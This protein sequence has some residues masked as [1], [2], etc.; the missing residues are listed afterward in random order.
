MGPS[1]RFTHV[2]Y[3]I[4]YGIYVLSIIAGAKQVIFTQ[5]SCV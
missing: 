4:G 1:G 3:Y 2:M 5:Y